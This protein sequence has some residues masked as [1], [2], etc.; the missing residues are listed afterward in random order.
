M[1]PG[2]RGRT[3][4]KHLKVLEK[5]SRRPKRLRKGETQQDADTQAALKHLLG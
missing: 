4:T 3:L 5:A 1:H 2:E